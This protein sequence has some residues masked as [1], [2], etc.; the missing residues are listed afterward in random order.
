MSIYKNFDNLWAQAT[1]L[2]KEGKISS[3]LT[4]TQLIDFA[5]GN[6]KIE[7]PKVTREIATLAI[8]ELLASFPSKVVDE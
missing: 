1:L 2:E 6:A 7:N 8:E 3:K 4:K 5:Y